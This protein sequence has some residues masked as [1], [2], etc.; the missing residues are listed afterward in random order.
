M[1]DNKP[2]VLKELTP[3]NQRVYEALLHA[4]AKPGVPQTIRL[5]TLAETVGI[6]SDAIKESLRRLIRAGISL[7]VNGPDGKTHFEG[8]LLS[9]IVFSDEGTVTVVIGPVAELFEKN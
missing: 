7:E 6:N 3:S 4:G 9:E 8:P 1:E 5:S 2:A